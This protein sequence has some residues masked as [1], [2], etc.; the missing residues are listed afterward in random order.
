MKFPM[1]RDRIVGDAG[2]TTA[3]ERPDGSWY[4]LDRY[5]RGCE[6]PQGTRVSGPAKFDSR[7]NASGSWAGS[8]STRG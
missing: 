8:R 6:L 5:G 1:S 7:D 4:A 3:Y 2:N